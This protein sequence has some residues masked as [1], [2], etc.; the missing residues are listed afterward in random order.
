[1][2][3]S[4]SFAYFAASTSPH[5]FRCAVVAWPY[6]TS[7]WT[8]NPHNSEMMAG[9]TTAL[10]AQEWHKRSHDLRMRCLLTAFSFP[11]RSGRPP[12]FT[13]KDTC[14]DLAATE[15]KWGKLVSGLSGARDWCACAILGS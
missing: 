1:M 6:R 2:A 10:K 15:Q 7:R 9:S 14:F 12:F 13:G 11:G 5:L 8:S 3:R 4:Q